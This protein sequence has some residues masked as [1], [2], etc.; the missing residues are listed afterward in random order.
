MPTVGL[1]H[2]E[3]IKLQNKP[4][5]KTSPRRKDINFSVLRHPRGEAHHP[6][7]VSKRLRWA[8]IRRDNFQ[9]RYC[10]ATGKAGAVLEVDHVI[11][12]SRGGRDVPQNLVTACE[13]CNSGKSDT[14]LD[15]P[16][17]EDV[18]QEVFLRSQAARD[19]PPP[20]DSEE[21]E[22]FEI[23]AA[24]AWSHA[25]NPG[26]LGFGK[27]HIEFALAIAAGRGCNEILTA[28]E[29]A[30]QRHDPDIGDFMSCF[31]QVSNGPEEDAAY[32]RAVEYLRQFIPSE[33]CEFIR[34]ARVAAGNYQPNETEIICA[35]G[36]IARQYDEEEGRDYDRLRRW[37]GHLP[38]GAGATHLADAAQEWD[39]VHQGDPKSSSEECPLEILEIAVR[40]ALGV[41]V[42]A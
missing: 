13:S 29:L 38:D 7:A 31:G 37:L 26:F 19:L 39:A 18:P 32:D 12:R 15:A 34:R 14:P 16:L 6:M 1:A 25:W 20:V 33:Q 35:A 27:Y 40:R 4:R 17:V 41:A 30:G 36:P 28:C 10:G 11:P 42:P 5:Q 9:C 24:V 3:N 23:Q 2:E 8:I 22:D 21:F